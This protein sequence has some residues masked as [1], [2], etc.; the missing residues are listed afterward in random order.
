MPNV[1]RSPD[2][3]PSRLIP[4]TRTKRNI[5]RVLPVDELVDRQ[6][7]EKLFPALEKVGCEPGSVIQRLK[8]YARLL[9]TWNRTASNLISR[10][11]ETRL[12]ERHLLECI[13]PAHWLKAS[14]ASR[15]LDFGTWAGLPGIPLALVGVGPDWTLVEARRTKTLFLLKTLPEIGL[16]SVVIS[17]TRLEHMTKLPDT[18]PRYAGFVS[19]AT[20]RLCPTLDLARHLVIPGGSAFLWK[21]SSR[22]Q[23]ILDE[24][25]WR[26]FWEPSGTVAVGTSHAVVARFI[27]T[28][29]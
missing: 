22:G 13:E 16:K 14:G 11:D 28:T 17:N 27:R 25:H 29:T 21:G 5:P 23:E 24:S 4:G 19:R 2:K 10:N 8:L 9:V 12:V 26:A 1:R 20:V 3:K 7:W 15:W 18:V 6:P